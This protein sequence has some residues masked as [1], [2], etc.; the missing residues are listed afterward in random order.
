MLAWR[1]EIDEKA[2]RDL[3]GLDAAQAHPV[4]RTDVG[5][6]K[7]LLGK[8]L[9]RGQRHAAHQPKSSLCEPSRA[10]LRVSASDLR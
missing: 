2:K 4:A 1:I 10:N 9:H 5:H 7:A 8:P 6:V 3:A